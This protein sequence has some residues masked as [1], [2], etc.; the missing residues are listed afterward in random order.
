MFGLRPINNLVNWY[1]KFN[2]FKFSRLSKKLEHKQPSFMFG[3]ILK[4]CN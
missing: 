2:L 4:N 1:K 3:L